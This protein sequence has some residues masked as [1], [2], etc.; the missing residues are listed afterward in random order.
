MA[1]EQ[2]QC[3]LNSIFS[4]INY[5]PFYRN[6]DCGRVSCRS[7]SCWQQG[8]QMVY[9]QTKNPIRVNCGG[10]WNAK[11]LY[12][13]G[14]FGIFHGHWVY[15]MEIWYCLWSFGNFFCF[16]FVW[17]KKNLA[18]Q[19][20]KAGGDSLRA[21]RRLFFP[22]PDLSTE[23]SKRKAFFLDGFFFLWA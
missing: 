1:A 2:R 10:P 22:F 3:L 19:A 21:A 20:G 23:K 8:C 18:T 15:F 13:L 4:P 14:Q 17:S 16:W 12:M 5:L 9:F 6:L 11:C 7:C